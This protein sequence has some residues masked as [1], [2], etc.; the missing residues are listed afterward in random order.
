MICTLS[1]KYIKVFI[2]KKNPTHH[3]KLLG[4][5]IFFSV[6]TPTS[7]QIP[8]LR[9]KDIY[10]FSISTRC[11]IP[12][13]PHVKSPTNVRPLSSPLKI[14]SLDMIMRESVAHRPSVLATDR[15]TH[16]VHDSSFSSGVIHEIPGRHA[17]SSSAL[18]RRRR[19]KSRNQKM[20][21]DALLRIT[22]LQLLPKR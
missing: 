4:G 17:S 12:H 7:L 22:V 9:N 11:F 8:Y 1:A 21:T 10:I 14:L 13:Y 20:Q 16:Q 3:Q 19:W 5:S 6:S 2:R 15:E 18:V